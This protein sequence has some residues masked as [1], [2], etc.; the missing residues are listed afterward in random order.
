ML[1]L[2]IRHVY[3]YPDLSTLYL[4]GGARHDA[5]VD[6][7]DTVISEDQWPSGYPSVS[8]ICSYG[9]EVS[10]QTN[11]KNI[12]R[13]VIYRWARDSAQKCIILQYRES[14]QEWWLGAHDSES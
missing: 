12:W 10:K 4:L 1:L 7:V 5:H 2:T 11:K 3:Y 8:S 13:L 6:D 14:V 9:S